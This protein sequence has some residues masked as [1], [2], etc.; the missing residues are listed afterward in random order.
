M[1]W[2]CSGGGQ[3]IIS[4]SSPVD[5]CEDVVLLAYLLVKAPK[6]K[7]I[8]KARTMLHFISGGEI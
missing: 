6:Y 7:A 1:E 8:N 3:I 5:V 2:K 4:A